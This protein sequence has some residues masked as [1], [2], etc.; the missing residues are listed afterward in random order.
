[1]PAEDGD[2]ISKDFGA[3]EQELSMRQIAFAIA[4]SAFGIAAS[5]P[6]RADYTVIQFSSGHCEVWHDSSD[7]PWGVGWRRLAFGL[8]TW[9]AAMATLDAARVQDLCP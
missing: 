1:L 8:P 2:L 3:G 6:A 5:N 9:S 4:L 7:N